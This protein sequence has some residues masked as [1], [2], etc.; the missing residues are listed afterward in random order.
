VGTSICVEYDAVDRVGMEG[1]NYQPTGLCEISM[2]FDGLFL[3][4]LLLTM[5]GVI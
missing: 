5:I 4:A 3:A 1:V 2:G